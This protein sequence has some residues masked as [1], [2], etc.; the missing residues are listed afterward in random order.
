MKRPAWRR[1]TLRSTT[2]LLIAAALPCAA[3]GQPDG[4]AK[5]PKSFAETVESLEHQP[6]FLDLYWDDVEGSVMLGI[7][8]F[9]REMLFVPGMAAGVGSNDIGIDRGQIGRTKLVEFRRVGKKV[10]LVQKNHRYRA[11]SDSASESRSVEEAFAESVLWG[12]QVKAEDEGSGRVLIDAT[13]FLLSDQHD[14]VARLRQRKQGTFRLDASRS[15]AYPP[16]IKSFPENTELEAT[17]TFTGNPEGA[18]LRSVAPTASAVTVRQ[19]MSFIKLPDDGYTPRIHDPRSGLISS[20]F[21]DYAQPIESPLQRRLVQR[22]RLDKKNPGADKSEAVEPIVYYLDPGTP[23]PVRSALLDGAR[24]WNQAFEAAGYVDAFQV[25][26]LPDDA[27]PLDVRYN[28]IQWVH[29]STRGW[30]YGGSIT[31]PRTGE[32][33]KGIVTLG[34]LRVRQDYMIAQA[35]VGDTH[36]KGSSAPDPM[37]QM[38]LARLRQLSAHEVGHTIGLMHNFAAS[39]NDRASV[40][41]YPH[42]Q[43]GFDG[44]R[45]TLAAAYA[46]G[47]GDWDK[48]A[49]IFG[50]QDFPDSLGDAEVARALEDILEET[51]ATLLYLTD[52]DARPKGGASPIAHIWDNGGDPTDELSH[53]LDVRSKVLARFGEDYLQPGTPLAHLED[54]LVPLFLVHRYQLDAAAKLVGGL[55][56]RYALKGDG[57]I[58]TEMIDPARQRRALA[59]LL[60]SLDAEELTVPE[61]VL[62]SIA[63]RIPGTSR[64]REHFPGRTG[65]I[66]DPLT[67]ADVAADLTLG[68]LLHHE[69]AGRLVINPSRDSSQLGIFE[70]L[71]GI[72]GATWKADAPTGLGAEVKRVVE[73]ATLRHLQ[74]LATH[75]GALPQARAAALAS[76]QELSDW[77]R[78]RAPADRGQAAHYAAAAQRLERF[79]EDP[80]IKSVPGPARMPDGDP[81]GSE[82]FQALE[83]LD[84][85]MCSF[86]G[87]LDLN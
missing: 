68:L 40:M 45:P 18:W 61:N 15:A 74:R 47:I 9:N 22:H 37:L 19:H 49:V 21:F 24:W 54:L 71:D 13:P 6:G 5:T 44:D 56:Y 52:Q 41:D 11:V 30:S 85:G 48:R 67:A 63:P 1:S 8:A 51:R 31:D 33:L 80:E 82:A 23:E 32:I 64:G 34:S 25:E 57:Q 35:L 86:V 77:L 2:A 20:G 36:D 43:V 79:L 81:I 55:D 62:K 28:I 4:A 7:P 16:R 65:V 84:S 26:M 14:V 87:E 70:V 75:S 38:A 59:A 46:T 58:A 83:L 12:F 27:D 66:F 17:L 73:I 78:D 50:Y 3:F 60:R 53:L 10:L 42:P 72:I 76:V 29:R 39:V 69:R